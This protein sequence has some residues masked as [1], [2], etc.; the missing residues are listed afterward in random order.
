[1][2]DK[3][4]VN[5]ENQKRKTGNKS[6]DLDRIVLIDGNSLIHR[7]YHALPPLTT[8]KGQPIG[9]IYGFTSMLL[10]VLET[11]MPKYITVV[12]DTA[13][14]TFREDD[15][16]EYKQH[17][18]EVS[19]D[20]IQQFEH[21]YR[22]VESL[23]I[24]Q[25]SLAGY[26]ADD[27]IG[28]ITAHLSL[29]QKG[30]L[31]IVVVT[32]DLD[33]LQLV[34]EHVRV[35]TLK[36][37]FSDTV[38][39]DEEMVQ[40]RYHGLAPRQLVDYRALR[41]DPSDNIPG[42]KGVGD[43]T[44]TELL[45]K[46]DNLDRLY[47]NLNALT[48]RQEQ[49]LQ[50]GKESAYLSQK[51]AQIITDVPLEFDL[52][53]AVVEDYDPENARQV[54]IE[55]GFRSLVGRLPQA[56]PS[57]QSIPVRSRHVIPDVTKIEEL[58]A[59][60]E[61]DWQGLS[62]FEPQQ[63]DVQIA[64][65]LLTGKT[66][67][68][69]AYEKLLFEYW[70]IEVDEFTALSEEQQ[71]K[72]QYVLANKVNTEFELNGND[73]VKHLYEEVEMP[74]KLVLNEMSQQGA[75]I[76]R[77]LLMDLQVEYEG[78]LAD[79]AAQIRESVGYEFNLNSP[80]QLE[81]V[82]FD[83]LGL[84]VVKRTKTQRSTDESVLNKLRELHPIIEMLLKYR[85]DFKIKSTY[86]DPILDCLDTNNRIH[87]TYNQTRTASGR[88]SSESPNLQ[89][90]PVDE[91]IGIRKAFI[92]PPEMKLLIA[93]YSQIEL[94]IMAHYSNDQ[95]LISSFSHNQDIH[96]ATAAR[97]FDKMIGEVAPEERRIGKTINFALM[98][99]MSSFGL[100]ETLGIER[101]EAEK[102]INNFFSG[103]PGVREWQE[104]F[105]HEA[106]EKGYVETLFG[107]RRYLPALTS[108]NFHQRSAAERAALNHPLQGTQ[109]DILKIVMLNFAKSID[110][111]DF[112]VQMIL[113]IHDELVFEVAEEA[114]GEFA[115]QVKLIMETPVELSLPL[116]AD[117]KYGD[118]WQEVQPINY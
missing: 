38:L 60:E 105:L 63:F 7:A 71:L 70:G 101:F 100:S 39:Y 45:M 107:R 23:N 21:G 66:G 83:E 26:E 41:G 75:L 52:A 117:I 110:S 6:E 54:F 64:V 98:Y 94:R 74:L 78:R 116:K 33:L 30:R 113:Q 49:L 91:S 79:I 67:K 35:F 16:A 34:S 93:D 87:T 59:G 36:R 97:I 28:T 104:S 12:W 72:L 86:I 115:Q 40:E 37:G 5:E 18:P 106:R 42:V 47:E 61:V 108:T 17:R 109:A 14:P 118:N 82:L 31:E 46:F 3:K 15:F 56:N 9:A 44:A 11:L 13:E 85:H 103:Y 88:L 27:L 2:S 22:I 112:P 53:K 65:N 57:D 4:S 8:P 48:S 10:K 81:E 77:E 20:L 89:N 80:K 96:A 51:L 102:Y 58:L 76:N 24:P 19:Q 73:Q 114:V 43:K 92:A 95:G 111:A 55:Y 99:G 62:A 25:Y 29:G 32:G 1:M 69:L 50:K 68:E 84:P 90:I